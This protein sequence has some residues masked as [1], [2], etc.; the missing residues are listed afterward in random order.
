[1]TISITKFKKLLEEYE[2][3]MPVHKVLFHFPSTTTEEVS[4]FLKF[5]K[6]KIKNGFI[7]E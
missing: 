7:V 2:G 5:H 4:D 3:K 1:M 6:F